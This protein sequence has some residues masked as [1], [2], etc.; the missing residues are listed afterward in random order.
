MTDSHTDDSYQ[1]GVKREEAKITQLR[2]VAPALDKVNEALEQV[3]ASIPPELKLPDLP[4]IE[5]FTAP[6]P[7]QLPKPVIMP[8]HLAALQQVTRYITIADKTINAGRAVADCLR[9]TL[10][11]HPNAVNA[12]ISRKALENWDRL[13]G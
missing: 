8:G 6:V 3:K 13:L 9:A 5:P 7:P 10:E 1:D 12:A 4:A 2:K 11:A